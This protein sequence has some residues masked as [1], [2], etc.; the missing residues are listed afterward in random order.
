MQ[1][2]IYIVNI[3]FY[4][5]AVA[6]AWYHVDQ[7][8][9]PRLH[10]LVQSYKTEKVEEDNGK[11]RLC[12]SYFIGAREGDFHPSVFHIIKRLGGGQK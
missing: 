5:T 12:R 9:G 6:E 10:G 8:Y 2:P 1:Y 11:D 7:Y 4:I 3:G